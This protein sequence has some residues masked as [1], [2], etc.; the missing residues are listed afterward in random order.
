MTANDALAE[1]MFRTALRAVFSEPLDALAADHRGRCVALGDM[2]Q[3]GFIDPDT[4][5]AKA[6]EL[7]MAYYRA[8][9]MIRAAGTFPIAPLVS[10]AA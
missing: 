5:A 7:S 6:V 10:I 3:D 4:Y 1:D 9:T 2:A 8:V